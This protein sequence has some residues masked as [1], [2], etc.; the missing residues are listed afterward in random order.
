MPEH[1]MQRSHQIP[2]KVGTAH[3]E[4]LSRDLGIA[5]LECSP[6]SCFQPDD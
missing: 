1:R 2:P 4:M 3:F 6:F 5:A